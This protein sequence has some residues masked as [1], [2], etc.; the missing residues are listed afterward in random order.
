MSQTTN[1]DVARAMANQAQLLSLAEQTL[2]N[3][4]DVEADP[5]LLTGLRK[6]RNEL[7]T[8][9]GVYRDELPPEL[10]TPGDH[11]FT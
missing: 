9:V 2:E 5:E 3:D 6:A 10:R 4:P 7:L 11:D 1:H 8:S